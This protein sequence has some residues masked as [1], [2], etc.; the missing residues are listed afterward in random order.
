MNQASTTTDRD[1]KYQFCGLENENYSIKIDL[2]SLPDGYILTSQNSGND[3]EDSDINSNGVS[4]TVTIADAN[5]TTLDG[6]IYK[7][8]APT[9]C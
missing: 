3:I 9:Y 1:G 6:G 2:D 8:Q 4:E 7:P 5:N